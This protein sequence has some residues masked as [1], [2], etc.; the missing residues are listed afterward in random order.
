MHSAHG[1]EFLEH[2]VAADGRELAIGRDD[3]IHGVSH[4]AL[5]GRIGH[6]ARCRR[7][8]RYALGGRSRRLDDARISGATVHDSAKA[9]LQEL[10]VGPRIDPRADFAGEHA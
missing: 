2:L 4:A 5:L 10:D 3:D 8:G 9:G 6:R 1:I 7:R